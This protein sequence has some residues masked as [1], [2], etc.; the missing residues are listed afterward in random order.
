MGIAAS[1]VHSPTPTLAA[2]NTFPAA[3]KPSIPAAPSRRNAPTG[4]MVSERFNCRRRAVSRTRMFQITRS[5]DHQVGLRLLECATM[6]FGSG[7]RALRQRYVPHVATL[8]SAAGRKGERNSDEL[9]K[10]V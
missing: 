2:A 4:L 1:A 3:S 6:R 9:S 8:A 7:I 10:K 5:S